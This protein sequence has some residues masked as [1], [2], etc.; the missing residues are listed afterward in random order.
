MDKFLEYLEELKVKKNK[1]F[2]NQAVTRHFDMTVAISAQLLL[3]EEIK[4][5]YIE[6]KGT[7]TNG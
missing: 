2:D 1:E 7:E 6:L 5:G 4:K 3:L